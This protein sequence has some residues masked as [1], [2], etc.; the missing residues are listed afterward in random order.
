ML[1]QIL[2][3][4]EVEAAFLAATALPELASPPAFVQG[5][6]YH[7]SELATSLS[8]FGFGLLGQDVSMRAFISSVRSSQGAEPT[9][10]L[11]MSCR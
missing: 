1:A 4:S 6:G 2:R 5:Y 10:K 9:K 8:A 7:A 3:A 11:S